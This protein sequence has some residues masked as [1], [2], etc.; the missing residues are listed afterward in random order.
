M[1]SRSTTLC[2][3]RITAFECHNSINKQH[4]RQMRQETEIVGKGT[5]VSRFT[6]AS[7]SDK[8]R[9]MSIDPSAG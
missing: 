8:R 5:P 9:K 6:T 1:L 3:Q 2:P 7:P 4:Q